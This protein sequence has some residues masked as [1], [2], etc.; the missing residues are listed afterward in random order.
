VNKYQVLFWLTNTGTHKTLK[1]FMEIKVYLV[2][3]FEWFKRLRQEH[4][5]FKDD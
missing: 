3:V 5:N 2:W 1:L 4:E